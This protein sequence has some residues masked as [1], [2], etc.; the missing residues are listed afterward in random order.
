VAIGIYIHLPFCR[1]HCAYC[2]FAVSTNIGQQ[3]AYT[4]AL[5]AEIRARASGERVDTIFFGGGTPSRTSRRNLTRV[6]EALRGAFAIDADAEFSLEANPEDITTGAI[7]F[8]S[9]LGVN[10]LSVGVQSFHDAELRPLGRVHGRERALEALRDAVAGGVRT[11]LDLILGLPNQTAA[12]FRETLEIAIASG[13]GHL[14]LY[15]LDLEEGTALAKQVE[16]GRRSLPDEDEV[17]SLYVEAVDRLDQAGLRQYEISNFG[18]PCLHNLRYWRREPYLGFGLAAHSFA[19]ERRFA[20]T[21]DLARY[22]AGHREGDVDEALGPAEQRR[23]TLFLRLRQSAGIGYDDVV[24]LCG[25]EGIEWM[26]RGLHDGWLRRDGA[27]VAFTPAGFLLSNDYI[28]QL[29]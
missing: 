7:D 3:D 21:R 17:A 22:I 23:E 16:S 19:G 8:W 29:F 10:R 24:S 2:P 1:V 13:V 9:G 27:R 12:S 15:M 25:E 4:D 14:S 11:S 26:A 28:S 18:E 5:I 20:N 6:V